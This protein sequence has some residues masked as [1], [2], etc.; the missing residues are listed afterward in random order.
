MSKFF[1][2]GLWKS[3]FPLFLLL[4]LFLFLTLAAP[5]SAA[6]PPEESRSDLI[7]I[8]LPDAADKQQMPDAL[9]LHDK[10]TRAL[11]DKNCRECHLKENDIFIFKF[12]RLKDAGYDA[13]KKMYH[14]KCISCHQEKRDQG[15]DSGPL[16]SECRLCHTQTSSYHSSTRPFGLDKSLHYRHVIAES[17][18]PAKKDKDGNC[19]QCHHEFDKDLNKTVYIKGKEG[20]CRYCHKTKKTD[21]ARSLKT[22]AHEDCLNCHFQ[23]KSDSK[24][25][26]PTDCAGC[27]DADKQSKIETLAEIPRIKRNQPDVALLSLWLKET[28][29]SEK[30]SPQ[31]MQPVAFNHKSHEAGTDNCYSC[32]H[33][34]MAPCNSCH[35][36]MGTEKSKYTRLGTAMHS[37]NSMT[38]CIGCHTQKLQQKDCAGCHSQI[39]SKTF[40]DSDCN[41]CHTVSRKLL[42]PVPAEDKIRSQIAE[43]EIASWAAPQSLIPE[44]EIPENVTIDVMKDQ[45]EGA[46]FPHRKIVKTLYSRIQDNDL[47]KHFHNGSQTMCSGCHHNSPSSVTPPKCASCH[48]VLPAPEPDGRPG[49]KGAYHAQCIGC[50]Q[51]M[52]IEKPAATDCISCHKLQTKSAQQSD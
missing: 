6:S 22:V 16:T 27:H 2:T 20:T 4:I 32:H 33:K 7:T 25:A 19:G 47:A 17:I 46:T 36:R 42:E 29:N 26:G 14:K 43:S 8:H 50:H 15:I 52:G 5:S 1:S 21:D 3:F 34:S 51:K 31:F 12:N 11:K 35:T 45:Y 9:F 38:S 23:L 30:P 28:V 39:P 40:S 49:L 37:G 44:K 41:K 18:K 13:D 10:H 48:G 24:K